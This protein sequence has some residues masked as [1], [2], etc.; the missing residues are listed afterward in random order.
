MPWLQIIRQ[1]EA[2]ADTAHEFMQLVRAELLGTRVFVF[3]RNGRILNLQRGATL[4]DAANN[5]Q[6]DLQA[7]ACVPMLNGRP[8]AASQELSN[9]DIVAFERST[10]LMLG[11]ATGQTGGGAGEGAGAAEAALTPLN[12]PAAG[13]RRVAANVGGGD[14][15]GGGCAGEDHF[16]ASIKQRAQQYLDERRSRAAG[17][18]LCPECLP[19]PGDDLVGVCQAR[20][21]AAPQGADG[22]ASWGGTIHCATC[23]CSAIGRQLEADSAA[24]LLK[25]QPGDGSDPLRGAFAAALDEARRRDAGLSACL[26]VYCTDRR[27]ATRRGA[28]GGERAS[29]HV[30]SRARARASAP[31][32]R[33]TAERAHRCA[34]ALLSAENCAVLARPRGRAHS[35]MDPIASTARACLSPLGPRA[36]APNCASVPL[37]SRVGRCI[38][39]D[40]LTPAAVA[41]VAAHPPARVRAGMLVDVATVVTA[42]ATNIV[43]VHS[44]IFAAGGRSVFKY[45]VMVQDR[46]QLETLMEA[47]RQ[48]S[49]VTSVKRGKDYDK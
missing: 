33:R 8:A 34:D 4:A 45:E 12:L 32:R 49:D 29:Q 48:V 27:G 5:L 41:A 7:T 19:L 2:Q 37:A 17:W 40:R 3:T 18:A 25:P 39:R 35:S 9:G 24:T 21:A 1:W 43:N 28:R 42:H 46:T 16:G 47:L 38:S 23:G 6:L 26:L 20:V 30:T 14:G 36:P 44:N 15:D 13:G 11:W 22:G 10:D 31:M